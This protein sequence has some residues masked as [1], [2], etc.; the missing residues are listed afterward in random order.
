MQNKMLPLIYDF[1]FSP[2][3]KYQHWKFHPEKIVAQQTH[4]VI[5]CPADEVWSKKH[6]SHTPVLRCYFWQLEWDDFVFWLETHKKTQ[7]KENKKTPMLV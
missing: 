7:N 2:V 4:L 1:P 5:Q 6:C 3:Y